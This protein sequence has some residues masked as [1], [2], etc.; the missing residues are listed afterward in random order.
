LL[1]AAII[2][3][4]M[5]GLG[6]ATHVFVPHPKDVGAR[7]KPGHDAFEQA[8]T[9][10]RQPA[11]GQH[12]R[13]LGE[14]AMQIGFNLP[15]SGAFTDPAVMARLAREGE[16]LGYDYLTLTDHVVLPDTASPGYPY[17]E[18]GEF[19]SGAPTIRHELLTAVAWVAAKTERIRLVTAVLVVPHRPA[20]LAAKM[21]ASIDV[22]SGGRLVVGVGAGWLQAEFDAVATTPFAERGAVTD[23]Y[24][25]AFRALWTERRPA[26]QGKYTA[27]SDIVLEPKPVQSPH[28]PIWVGGES[29]PALRRAARLADAW[30]P[31]GTNR[32]HPFDSLPRLQA[33]IARLRKLA[34]D[35]GRDPASLGV[36]Y[37]V[38]RLGEGLPARAGDGER[39]LFSGAE[40]DIL[41]DLRAL[42]EAGVT[43]LDV[44]IERADA[45]ASIAELRRLRALLARI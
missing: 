44:E 7:A 23:E 31:I 13:I 12:H 8:D 22:L 28:P 27:F 20:V 35:A 4:V 42:R 19:L 34:A 43:G 24:L 38:K 40:A 36:V 11:R 25:H 16:A 39:R 32:A 14:A 9:L 2:S 41:A 5:A 45:D 26:F 33:G 10:E 6:P 21:L 29:P 17:S 3:I 37:R 18:S 15:N 1:L 30:Y